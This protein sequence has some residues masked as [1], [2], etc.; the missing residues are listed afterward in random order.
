MVTEL[1]ERGAE[2]SL[3]VRMS[4]LVSDTPGPPLSIPSLFSD[5]CDPNLNVKQNFQKPKKNP[6]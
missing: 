4:F 1:D 5:L 6:S 3:S 2:D